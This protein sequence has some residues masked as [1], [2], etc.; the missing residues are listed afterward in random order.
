VADYRQLNDALFHAGTS[1]GSANEY[2]DGPNSLHFYILDR[3]YDAAGLEHYKLGIQNPAGAGPQQRGVAITG[4]TAGDGTCTFTVKNTGVNVATDP[5]LH[6][7]DETASFGSDIYRLSASASG[8]H[9]Y[10]R[11]DLGTAKFGDSFQV[12]VYIDPAGGSN[13]VTLTATS[14]SDPSVTS[15]ATCG[16]TSVGG[17][18]PATLSLSL[19]A[20][21]SFGG[22]QPGVARDYS[23]S[24][25]VDVVSTAGDATLSVSDPSATAPGHLVNGAFVVPQALQAKSGGTY[26]PVSGTPAALRTWSAPTSHEPVSVDFQQSIAANDALR[27]GTYAKTLTFTLSTTQ[28]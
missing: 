9:A 15:T 21:A 17:T 19:G 26:A 7:Q 8:S 27:T 22:F 18:V 13:T 10:L 16:Q 3:Y 6:P 24:T 23:A 1:S 12:P 11:N 20:P 4:S 2:V 5:S 28:P 14:V 25:P